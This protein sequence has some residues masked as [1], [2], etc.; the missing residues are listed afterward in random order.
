M[1]VKYNGRIYTVYA[2]DVSENG[3]VDFF[4]HT[5]V[6]KDGTEKVWNW[7]AAEDCVEYRR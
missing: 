6:N 4:L 2:V 1:L 7:I 3:S 5:A